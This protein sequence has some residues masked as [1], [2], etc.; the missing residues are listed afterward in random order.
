MY[1]SWRTREHP[2]VCGARRGDDRRLTS[3]RTIAG[4]ERGAVRLGDD[5]RS[6][7]RIFV[8][9]V[10]RPLRRGRRQGSGIGRGLSTRSRDEHVRSVCGGK[11]QQTRERE[12]RHQQRGSEP[13]VV[14]HGGA[15]VGVAYPRSSRIVDDAFNGRSTDKM[16]ETIGMLKR[17]T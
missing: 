8:V 7:L 14:A 15:G 9:V 12:Q 4:I 13:A 3:R 2:D 17:S 10:D 1:A 11:A 6:A 5:T 16:R